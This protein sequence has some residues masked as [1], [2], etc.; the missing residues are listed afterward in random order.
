MNVFELKKL[1]NVVPEN[2]E[3]FINNKQEFRMWHVC[4]MF[5]KYPDDM[6]VMAAR[7]AFDVELHIETFK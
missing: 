5:S 3:I 1:L 4:N 6:M 2:A 7:K